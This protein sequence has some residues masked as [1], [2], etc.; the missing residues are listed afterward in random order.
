MLTIAAAWQPGDNV[1]EAMC[2]KA[3]QAALAHCPTEVPCVMAAFNMNPKTSQP[4]FSYLA[5]PIAGDGCLR[6]DGMG[7]RLISIQPSCSG[8]FKDDDLADLYVLSCR[9][10]FFGW[11]QVQDVNSPH[12][13]SAIPI[14]LAVALSL[15]CLSLCAVLY[16]SRKRPVRD[17]GTAQL[18]LS[19]LRSS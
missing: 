18:E 4:E 1:D 12:K 13:F 3:H 16:C 5:G 14:I 15:L 6:L 8:P 7:K 2:S 9:M 11:C 10:C 17:S 19:T